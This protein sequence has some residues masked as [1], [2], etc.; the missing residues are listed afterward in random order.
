MPLNRLLPTIYFV[1]HGET[2]WNKQGLIQGSVDT[3]LNAQ[4]VEQVHAVAN[5]LLQI[6]QELFGFDYVCSPQKRAQHTMRVITSTLGVSMDEVK[7]E[8]RVRE[9]GFGVWEGKP[10]WEIKDSP[11][12][13]ADQEGKFFWR[14]EGG[15]SYEDGVARVDDWLS[16]VSQPTLVVAHGA[17]GRCLMGYV[18]GL[19]PASI[20]SLKTPQGCYCK[21]ENGTISWFDAHHNAA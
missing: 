10:F 18:A 12:Y 4:G 8:P 17:V 7:T 11:V 19:D 14:P 15:E 21:L 2:D 6:R 16:T 1:R 9:L 13:P 20:V 5:A 3:D